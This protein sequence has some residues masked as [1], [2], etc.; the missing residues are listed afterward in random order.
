MRGETEKA[1]LIRIDYNSVMLGSS[2]GKRL[3]TA[4]PPLVTAVNTARVVG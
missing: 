1:V 4:S 2:V 3:L